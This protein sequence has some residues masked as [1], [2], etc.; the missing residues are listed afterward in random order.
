M[1]RWIVSTNNFCVFPLNRRSKRKEKRRSAETRLRL[2]D[3][4][5]V[6][7]ITVVPARVEIINSERGLLT[8]PCK[9]V[10][11]AEVAESIARLAE[12]F[13]ERGGSLDPIGIGR[14]RG[15]A[16]VVTEQVGQRPTRA[17]GDSGRAREVVFGD[18]C[19]LHFV[20]TAH[21]C[22]EPRVETQS[23]KTRS[24]RKDRRRA[25]HCGQDALREAR[26]RRKRRTRSHRRRPRPVASRHPT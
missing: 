26:H 25:I 20:V 22:P 12:G 5:K 16:E 6:V 7:K 17:D 8:L 21:A 10:V 13:V 11:R 2:F 23:V 19:P 14:D 3:S 9:M 18:R 15:T 4:G 24:R 1:L